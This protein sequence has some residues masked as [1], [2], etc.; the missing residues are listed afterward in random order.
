M[1]IS[2]DFS[3]SPPHSYVSPAVIDQRLPPELHKKILSLLSSPVEQFQVLS[4]AVLRETL[5]P[6]GQ[7]LHHNQENISLNDHAAALLLT[8]VSSNQYV[9]ALIPFYLDLYILLPDCW[10]N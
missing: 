2:P 10:S 6:S 8:Q 1:V 7:E 3:Q 9:F 4:S 5:P